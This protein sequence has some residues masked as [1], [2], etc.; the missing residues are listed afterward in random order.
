MKVGCSYWQV[1]CCVANC[2]GK[3]QKILSIR[4]CNLLDRS[5]NN[6]TKSSIY[7]VRL[8]SRREGDEVKEVDEGDRYFSQ[9]QVSLS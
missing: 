4:S 9:L 3:E 6:F 7:L 8:F 5:G 2:G 1:L